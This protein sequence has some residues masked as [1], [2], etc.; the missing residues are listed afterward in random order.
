ME[1]TVQWSV[2]QVAERAKIAPE[3]IRIRE[4]LGSGLHGAH[5]VPASRSGAD[6]GVKGRGQFPGSG[7]TISAHLVAKVREPD[8]A[9][10]IIEDAFIAT[11]AHRHDGGAAC[12]AFHHA[13]IAC[14]DETMEPPAVGRLDPGGIRC[15]RLGDVH[16]HPF[17]DPCSSAVM[18]C[19]WKRMKSTSVG[20]RI[21]IVPAHR[22]GMS[23][24]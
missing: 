17:T 18:M 16:R 20:R 19:R 6:R 10:T 9:I 8:A 24:A 2:E 1:Q 3:R 23:V 22:S 14:L 15:A 21:R 5:R 13:A 11:F 7:T 4:Q 12:A